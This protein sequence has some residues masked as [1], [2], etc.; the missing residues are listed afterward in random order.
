[1]GTF[2]IVSGH[3]PLAIAALALPATALA[4]HLSRRRR[5]EPGLVLDVT[6]TLGLAD[7]PPGP[8][9]V[10]GPR[11][12]VR[13]VTLATGRPP[14]SARQ[15]EPWMALL[16]PAQREVTWLEDDDAAPSWAEVHVTANGSELE[17]TAHGQRQV[18]PLP[19]VS[20]VNAE[21]SARRIAA[22]GASTNLPLSVRWAELPPPPR[23]GLPVRLG[24]GNDGPVW[25]DLVADGPHVLVAGTTGSGKSEALRTIIASLAYDLAPDQVTFA[26]IDF[27][28]GAGLGPCAGLPHVGS[29]LTDLEPHSARRCLLALVAELA[30]RKRACAASGATGFDDWVRDR[31]PRLVV[32]VDEFQEIAAA[33]R[34]FV[35]ELTRLA[36]Q[37]RS[38]GIHLVLATQRPAG[39]VGAQ[40]RANIGTTLALRTASESESRDLLGSSAAALIPANLPG[41][42]VLLRGTELEPVQVALPVVDAPPA[43]RVVGAPEPTARSLIA[44]ASTRHQGR[45]TALWL[46]E[47][48]ARLARADVAQTGSGAFVIGIRDEPQRRSRSTLHWDPASGPA[49]VTGPPRSGRSTTLITIAAACAAAGLQP[50]A[51][52]AQPRLAVRTLAIALET[53]NAV[54]LVDDAARTLTSAATADP[55]VID[56]LAAAVVRMPVALVVPPGWAMHRLTANAGL[57]I[58]LAGLPDADDAGWSVPAELRTLA[59]RPGRARASDADGWT[60]AQVSLPGSVSPRTVVNP[61]PERVSIALTGRAIGIGGDTAV[62]FEVPAALATVV[63]PAGPERDGVARRLAIATGLEPIVV[64]SGFALGTPVAP[65]TRSI[66]CVRPTPRSLREV[67]RELPRGLLDPAPIPYRAIVI[68]DGHASTVQVLPG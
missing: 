49:V 12:L 55:D 67:S 18:A 30:D 53:A 26:L 34:E 21:A 6:G 27:K 5:P 4:V 62:P 51:V 16:S 31:P 58:V 40:I 15:Y 54:L 45:A 19:L 13:A 35:P 64:D 32:V 2:A 8:V 7:L 9:A 61:L 57:R 23:A 3:W 36:A 29:V 47:L 10:R 1:M 60:E 22:R 11:G 43:V 50:I 14:A 37:G 44:A 28:G 63:G 38:L 68:V 52:P 46:P 39:A 17:L 59:S 24:I 25:L 33:D 41:R 42:A 66:V 20:A 56:L 48:P 65:M